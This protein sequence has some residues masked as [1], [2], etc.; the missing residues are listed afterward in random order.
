MFELK[1]KLRVSAGVFEAGTKKLVKK[2]FDYQLYPPG[3]HAFPTWDG[4]DQ[5]GAVYSGPATEIKVA[6]SGIFWEW[7][8]V[9]GNNSEA[10][11]WKKK[12]TGLGMHANYQQYRDAVLIGD[13]LY[14]SAGFAEANN[15]I[16]VIDINNPYRRIEMQPQLAWMPPCDRIATD[17][18]Y[19]YMFGGQPFD[20]LDNGG[21]D[22]L[23]TAAK[24]DELGDL[25]KYLEFQGATSHYGVYDWRGC[26]VEFR[27]DKTAA[28]G[29]S[30]QTTGDLM[31][32]ARIEFDQ[33]N[34]IQ[35]STGIN[36]VSYA[37]TDVEFPLFDDAGHL[38][39]VSSN[40][41]Y[42]A[43]IDSAG[44]MT[45]AVLIASFNNVLAI[46]IDA[47]TS[48]IAVADRTATQGDYIKAY[49]LTT[50]GL[51]WEFGMKESYL[52]DATVH[53]DKFMFVDADP[54]RGQRTFIVFTPTGGMIV[55]DQGNHRTQFFDAARNLTHS[56]MYQPANYYSRIDEGDTKRVFSQGQEFE[57][58]WDKAITPSNDNNMWK[59]VRNWAI[60]LGDL[61]LTDPDPKRRIDSMV[62]LNTLSNG[63][64]YFLA[65]DEL[66][67]EQQFIE[68]IGGTLR[69]TGTFVTGNS[70]KVVDF[71]ASGF[72]DFSILDTSGAEDIETLYEIPI[73]GFD[74][75]N[76]PIQG[77]VVAHSSHVVTP[78]ESPFNNGLR[79]SRHARIGDDRVIF[80]AHKRDTSNGITDYDNPNEGDPHLGIIE[81]NSTE[82]R[83]Q[84]YRSKVQAP[85]S[86][87]P[88]DGTFDSRVSTRSAAALN[89]YST[90]QI[91]IR[92]FGEFWGPGGQASW[93]LVWNDLGLMTAIFGNDY[94]ASN[95]E[96]RPPGHSG[97]SYSGSLVEI[98][99]ELKHIHCD[100]QHQGGVSL[101]SCSNPNDVEIFTQAV[102]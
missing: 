47:V 65:R 60:Q 23:V 6:A 67:R 77:A 2:L 21:F 97:N 4:T 51:S 54:D 50:F 57:V 63:R 45:G 74:A 49:D 11:P 31:A 100:E 88:D 66:T 86:P 44:A 83:S 55:G 71:K 8:G 14:L 34:I 39:Y 26:D 30:V 95:K 16:S 28:S 69:Q 92:Y 41:L 94:L 99:G 76:N 32:T 43:D 18:E 101:W 42:R 33:L 3:T 36:L 91:L 59:L 87:F 68:V 79:P 75:S 98:N 7:M 61:P 40:D 93:A 9:I 24:T 56:V 1:R 102:A 19:L 29:L 64:T 20:F 85:N 22:T 27:T 78:L 96:W 52:T 72:I 15:V 48:A 35:K 81:R 46:A 13:A 58:D 73:T 10:I 82:L 62:G 5:S 90:G 70:L 25:D 37:L 84:F 80:Q 89:L 17:G 12:R 38:Y 53:D